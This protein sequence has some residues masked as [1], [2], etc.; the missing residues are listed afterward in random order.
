MTVN[1]PKWTNR[2]PAIA[3][4]V[5]LVGGA[6]VTWFVW[7]YFSPKFT[8]VGYQP[9][10]PIA[11]SHRLHAGAMGMDCRYCH[12]NVE[13]GPHANV[14]ETQTC[15]NC[16]KSVRTDR[17]EIQKLTA[18]YES[19]EP[20]RWKKVHLLPDFAYFT[21]APHIRA[22]VG[23]VSCHGR[24]DQMEVV[25]QVEPLSMGWCLQCHRN[26]KPHIR[27]TSE[28]TNMHYVHDDA[29]AEKL[30]AEKKINPPTHCSA[31]HR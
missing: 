1:F 7:Y 25:R 28:V 11:Y 30:I 2:L 6:F 29:V 3:L 15:M 24:I 31:C 27:P 17:P 8:D 10:Q 26:P 16:H 12:T 20:I 13:V 23:C 18:A 4:G 9:I 14:P 22:G 21:H 5:V 19:G